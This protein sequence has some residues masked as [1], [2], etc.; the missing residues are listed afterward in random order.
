MAYFPNGTAGMVLA[1]QCG[2]CLHG[3][4]DGIG[5]PIALVQ[6]TYNYTQIGNAKLR[7]CLEYLI[8]KKGDCQMKPLIDKYYNENAFDQVGERPEYKGPAWGV[9]GDKL[10]GAEAKP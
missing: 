2:E 4:A 1:Y 7:E 8:D 10:L 9:L 6:F 3:M 5:C